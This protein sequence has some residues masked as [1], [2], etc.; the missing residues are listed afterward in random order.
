MRAL[1]LSVLLLAGCDAGS[2]DGPAWA[3]PGAVAT[4]DYEPGPDTLSVTGPGRAL[5]FGRPASLARAVEMRITDSGRYGYTGRGVRWSDVGFPSAESRFDSEARLPLRGQDI[6][7]SADGLTVTVL[8]DCPDPGLRRASPDGPLTFLRVPTRASGALD[9][10]G[11]CSRSPLYYRA[12]RAER[13]TVPAGTFDTV[14]I[15][16]PTLPNA[17]G[18][19]GVEYWSEEVGLVR[20]EASR[21]DGVL[22]ARFSRSAAP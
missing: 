19:L 10:W 7:A 17:E 14:V 13:V 16:G 6:G 11:D 4:F 9:V 5:P 22:Q 18:A 21:Y 8:H 2:G 20:Y 3:Q 1:F 12:V 15:E